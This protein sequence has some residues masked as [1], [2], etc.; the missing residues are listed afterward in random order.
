M[1]F[2]FTMDPSQ[3]GRFPYNEGFAHAGSHAG[4]HAGRDRDFAL[5]AG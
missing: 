2:A 5:R 4:S 3:H 1:Q